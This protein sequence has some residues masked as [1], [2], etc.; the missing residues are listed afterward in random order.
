MGWWNLFGNQHGANGA[1]GKNMQAYGPYDLMG[2][3]ECEDI[4]WVL[5]DA[6]N[7]GMPGTYTE[8]HIYEGSVNVC[9]AYNSNVFDELG[10]GRDFVAEDRKDMHYAKRVAHWVRLRHKQSGKIVF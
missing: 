6:K 7:A 1:A 4:N 3:Q 8:H 5:Q 9:M 10:Y 2:F